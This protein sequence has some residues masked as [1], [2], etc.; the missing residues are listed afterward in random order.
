M[1]SISTPI[2]SGDLFAPNAP[3][4][5]LY[6]IT[7]CSSCMRVKE[8]LTRNEIPFESINMAIEPERG[9]ELARRG[10][11]ALPVLMRG[12][13]HTLAQDMDDIAR[14]VEITND[15]IPL[16]PQELV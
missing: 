13:H 2:T 10:I 11:R 1:M 9:D 7:G 12:E 16:E 5:R 14:F 15:H 4:L 8:F 3:P 6:W